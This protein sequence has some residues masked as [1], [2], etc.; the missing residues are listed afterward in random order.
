[1][2]NLIEEYNEIVKEIFLYEKFIKKDFLFRI[3]PLE[4]YFILRGKFGCLMDV[5]LGK[6]DSTWLGL[7][8]YSEKN[9]PYKQEMV[10][11]MCDDNNPYYDIAID[12]YPMNKLCDHLKNKFPNINFSK[13]LKIH[14]KWSS[15]SIIARLSSQ[16]TGFSIIAWLFSNRSDIR[17][18]F[19]IANIKLE[20]E[21][22][23]S[24]LYKLSL[25]EIGAISGLVIISF[26]LSFVIFI[27]SKRKRDKIRHILEYATIREESL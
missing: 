18:K 4:I 20:F 3:N 11:R 8:I 15:T 12:D 5:F 27:S 6:N 22:F 26:S 10:R 2:S 21:T 7:N 16:I 23:F 9:T 25:P 24:S 14:D 17:N 19:S 13:L 1:M